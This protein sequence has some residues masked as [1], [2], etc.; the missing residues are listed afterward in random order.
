[1][2]R[3]TDPNAARSFVRVGTAHLDREGKRRSVSPS[4]REP[5]DDGPSAAPTRLAQ[6]GPVGGLVTGAAK[7]RGDQRL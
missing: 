6:I 7:L 5:R 4:A 2:P 3:P 1:M